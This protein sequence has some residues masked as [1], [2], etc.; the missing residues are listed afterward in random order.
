MLKHPPK[1]L[2]LIII[3][4]SD[5]P[6]PLM[7]LR[8]GNKMKEIR[9]S[10]LRLNRDEIKLFVKKNLNSKY[11]DLIAEKLGTALE[12]WFAGLRLAL[13]H[14]SFYDLQTEKIEDIFSGPGSPETYF[15]HEVLGHLDEPTIDFFLKTSIL[16]QFTPSL[17]GHI[18][19]SKNETDIRK[20]I[21]DLIR[22]NL[23]VINLDEKER[24]YRYHHLFQALL[25]KELLKRFPQE[26]IAG[27]HKRAAGWYENNGLIEDA[28]NHAVKSGDIEFL[29]A[30]VEK[31]ID[32]PLNED[33][34]YILERWLK[35]IPDQ[36]I[37]KSPALLIAQMWIFHHKSIIW[38]IPDQLSRLESLSKKEPFDEKIALQAEFFRSVILFWQAKIDES[39]AMFDHVRKNLPE[40]MI[41]AISLAEIYY[42][43]TSHMNGTG[44]KVY[45]EIEKK[46][47]R[48]NLNFTSRVILYGALIYVKLREGDLYVAER[49]NKQMYGLSIEKNDLFA[50]AWTSYF[51]GYIAFQQN[52]PEEAVSFFE[53][54]LDNIYFLNVHAPIDTF[55]GM[56]LALRQINDRKD[57]FDRVYDQLLSFVQGS[58]NPYFTAFSYSLR[59]RIALLENDPAS[60]VKLIKMSDMSFDSGNIEYNIE[61]P[62]LTHCAILLARNSSLKTQEAIQKL[63]EFDNI[64]E[65]TRNIPQMIR[66]Q[67]LK[68]VAYKRQSNTEKARE[69]LL[70]ALELA[71]PGNWK[72]PFIEAAPEILELIDTLNIN[73]T[74]SDFV[75][76]LRSE[77]SATNIPRSSNVSEKNDT[78]VIYEP[79]PLTNREMDVLTL[80]A[81]RLSNK[82]IAKELYISESTV[83][84]HTITI[85]Q[86][87]DV[88]RRREAVGKAKA[89]GII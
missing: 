25:Q 61:V 8:A 52:R 74:I 75:T 51:L 34:W 30:M 26:T 43:I 29:V 3:T 7:Q 80:L 37:E 49:L 67:I 63:L 33:K 58:N 62:R 56:L 48:N 11:N 12:G 16:N 84:R 10:Q 19:S 46:L 53:E 68:A 83:K 6:L 76:T 42:A 78:P 87:L 57:D 59:A 70:K 24:W 14:L 81:E 47:L 4:R 39:L 36:Y 60:A 13:L 21:D 89:M 27:L 15:L 55:A 32:T 22:R 86:K 44:K 20:L 1:N 66:S 31:H 2:H 54:A 69:S 82:E 5:P 45:E 40:E 38:A 28:L 72:Y 17:A 41:G 50:R 65:K 71:R 79:D 64:A 85:Y 88:H 77:L 18:I 23:F 9:S 73:E 35:K